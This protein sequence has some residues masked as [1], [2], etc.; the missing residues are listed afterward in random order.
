VERTGVD[1]LTVNDVSGEVIGRAAIAA[2][3]VI[4][5]MRAEGDDLEAIF[6]NL[7][8]PKEFVS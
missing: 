1:R 4:V 5:G 6:E 3:A 2:G 7:I 8:H